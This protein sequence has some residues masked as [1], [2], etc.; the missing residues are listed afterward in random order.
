MVMARPAPTRGQ[1]DFQRGVAGGSLRDGPP[2]G[3]TQRCAAEVGVEDDPGGV[4]RTGECRAKP[5][6]RQL[7]DAVDEVVGID[8]REC[9]AAE[10]IAGIVEDLAG[11]CDEQRSVD[12]GGFLLETRNEPF[13]RRERA[14]LLLQRCAVVVCGHDQRTRY[15]R[16]S[17]AAMTIA[18]T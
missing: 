8:V 11:E 7:L 12:A 4:D 9:A 18:I 14:E 10:V 2:R 13:N 6:D 16:A 5:A 17:P 1:V 3:L 15:P